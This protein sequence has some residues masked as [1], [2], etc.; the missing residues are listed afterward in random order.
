[1][2]KLTV[3]EELSIAIRAAA[4]E[5]GSSRE[6]AERFYENEPDFVRQ[7]QRE[8]AIGTLRLMIAKERG[9]AR[10]KSVRQRLGFGTVGKVILR[11]G[12]PYRDAT[13]TLWTLQQLRKQLGATDHPALAE[14]VKRIE[15]LTPYAHAE[16]GIT[17]PRA[18]QLALEEFEE[19]A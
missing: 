11:S 5:R 15:F 17:F 7:F 19:P 8:W 9:K 13:A 6:L 4:V 1:M 3:F 2:P 16:R 12:E 10:K 14:V 18:C